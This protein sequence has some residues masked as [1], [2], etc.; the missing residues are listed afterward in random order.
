MR[1]EGLEEY[2]RAHAAH[3]GFRP[4]D[5]VKLC[6]QG[7]FGAEHLVLDPEAAEEYFFAEYEKTPPVDGPLWE[8]ASPSY[9]RLSLA[10]FKGRGLPGAWLFRLFLLGAGGDLPQG[11]SIPRP[12]ASEMDGALAAV[13]RMAEAGAFPFSIGELDAYLLKYKASGGGPVHHSEAYREV[14]RPAYRVVPRALL[15]LLLLLEEIW[16]RIPK[17][18]V[19]AID[20]R[21]ASGKSTLGLLLARVLDAGV[22]RMDDFFLPP[23]LRR[24]ERFAAPG[25]N[26]HWERFAQEVLPYLKSKESFTYK[27]F[28]CGKMALGAEVLVPAAPYR[29]VEGS[30]SLHPAFGQYA[31]VKVFSTISPEAQIDRIRERNGE[32]LLRA[33]RERW[34]PWE[35]AYFAAYGTEG[36]ADL[37]WETEKTL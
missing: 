21:A 10:A 18:G 30:Y 14:N 29:I 2:L 17:G 6:Y 4:A 7:L 3:P 26:V 11:L 13:R 27:R 28:D 33:F 23:E 22:V 34:I 24:E 5:A 1:A 16:Q 37:L 32:A 19:I 25:G 31:D 36:G 20:G 9:A 35:E 15:S 8:N 12:D